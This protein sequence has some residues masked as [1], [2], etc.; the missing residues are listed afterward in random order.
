MVKIIEVNTKEFVEKAKANE[1]YLFQ[2]TK[3]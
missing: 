1:N 2:E 3:S